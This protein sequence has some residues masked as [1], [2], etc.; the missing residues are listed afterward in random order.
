MGATSCNNKHKV[1]ETH[2]DTKSLS[3]QRERQIEVERRRVRQTEGHHSLLSLHRT[4]LPWHSN[5]MAG[6]SDS[7]LQG[8]CSV[9]RWKE[10]LHLSMQSLAL[11]VQA[12]IVILLP[13]VLLWSINARRHICLDIRCLKSP[14]DIFGWPSRVQHRCRTPGLYLTQ[15]CSTGISICGAAQSSI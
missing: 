3:T 1:R 12:H 7:Y 11:F 15:T 13:P 8:W 2:C 9:F 10:R 5:Q 14:A 6:M 4:Q